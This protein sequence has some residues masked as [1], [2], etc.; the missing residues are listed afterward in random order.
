[1]GDG[2][3]EYLGR[4]DGQVKVRGYRVEPE[5]VAQ[6]LRTE[7]G[8]AAAAVIARAGAGG[9]RLVGYVVASVDAPVAA[10]WEDDVLERLRV[11]LPSY[12]V[13]A[14]LMR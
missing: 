4:L 10:G 7:P 13:P 8:V 11:K 12:M 2:S 9:L 1:N 14:A 6:A 5:E 3:L